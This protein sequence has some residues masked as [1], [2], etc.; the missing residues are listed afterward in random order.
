MGQTQLTLEQLRATAGGRGW[1]NRPY[2]LVPGFRTDWWQRTLAGAPRDWFRFVD[3]HHEELVRVEVKPHSNA[4]Y[5]GVAV[6]S[7]GFAEVTFFEVRDGHRGCGYGTEAIELLTDFYQGQRLAAFSER[8][9]GFWDSVGW[10]PH[11]P[12]LGP[13]DYEG[14][15]QVFYVS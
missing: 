7:D 5:E 1:T 2:T 15:Y 3:P 14:H 6:P 9:D 12:R 13:D 10:T 4:G 11:L 8:A